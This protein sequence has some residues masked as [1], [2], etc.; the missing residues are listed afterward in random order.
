MF[1]PCVCRFAIPDMLSTSLTSLT[2]LT[3]FLIRQRQWWRCG[4]SRRRER[5]RSMITIA[6]VSPAKLRIMYNIVKR[7]NGALRPH[8]RRMSLRRKLSWH[9]FLDSSPANAGGS[10]PRVRTRRKPA[11]PSPCSR[12]PACPVI[13][14]TKSQPRAR[15]LAKSVRSGPSTSWFSRKLLFM[16][17]G[18]RGV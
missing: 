5:R 14:A 3:K 4:R 15:E 2:C 17:A 7:D 1:T 6:E 9:L 18:L 16:C 8:A 12:G 13:W 11:Q 10:S